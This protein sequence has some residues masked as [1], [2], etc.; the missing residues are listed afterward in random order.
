M[1]NVHSSFTILFIR[2]TRCQCVWIP[3][4]FG[5]L[6]AQIFWYFIKSIELSIVLYIHLKAISFVSLSLRLKLI[7]F[8]NVC[9]SIM[10]MI[11]V[12]QK[13]PAFS[14]SICVLYFF[15]FKS[16]C[17][18]SVEFTVVVICVLLFVSLIASRMISIEKTLCLSLFCMKFINWIVCA[19]ANM[20]LLFKIC[21]WAIFSNSFIIKQIAEMRKNECFMCSAFLLSFFF[22]FGW[23]IAFGL[24]LSYFFRELNVFIS[25]VEF[26]I[27]NVNKHIEF[28]RPLRIIFTTVFFSLFLNY[29]SSLFTC[30]IFAF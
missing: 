27:D 5:S 10:S 20:L 21:T 2:Y 16:G 13:N 9:Y 12:Y 7:Y 17:F 23:S 14:S 4:W 6:N 25:A 8:D 22:A 28:E 1:S 19:F 18:F 3:N 15:S 24:F 26:Q 30:I 29:S 11:I